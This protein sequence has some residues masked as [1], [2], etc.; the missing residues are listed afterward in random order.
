MLIVGINCSHSLLAV[1]VTKA[2]LSSDT[3]FVCRSALVLLQVLG[4]VEAWK[5]PQTHAAAQ[6]AAVVAHAHVE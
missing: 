3:D 5:Q 6:S 4:R 2:T 1:F